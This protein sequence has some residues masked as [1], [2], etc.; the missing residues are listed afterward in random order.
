MGDSREE[1][2]VTRANEAF[3]A[4]FRECDL[5]AMEELWAKDCEVAV[6]HPG[7]PSLHTL[8][9]VLE[10]WQRIFEGGASPELRCEA[11]RAVV[12]GS[13]AYVICTE[14][15]PDGGGELIASNFF[16]RERGEW[17]L[18]LHQAGP[19]PVDL[20]GDGGEFVH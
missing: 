9:A 10:S 12:L 11:P 13:S 6:I 16:V 20:P 3:Y 5:V 1:L 14:R 7:W 19:A 18:V 8:E 2:E 15:L 4:A 17:R